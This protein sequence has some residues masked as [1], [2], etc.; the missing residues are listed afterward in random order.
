[1]QSA[2]CYVGGSLVRQAE[3]T[4]LLAICLF[5][6]GYRS[7]SEIDVS[8]MVP[9]GPRCAVPHE[10]CRH[11]DASN[12]PCTPTGTGTS[13]SHCTRFNDDSG[14]SGWSGS[15]LSAAEALYECILRYYADPVDAG[16]G[17]LDDCK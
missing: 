17:H 5:G 10:R 14:S 16:D 11:L 1:M 13:W 2:L 15:T 7:A 12:S 9:A 4:A 6:L 8:A 3:R